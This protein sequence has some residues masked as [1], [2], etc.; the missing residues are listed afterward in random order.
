MIKVS[1]IRNN[2]HAHVNAVT[3][4]TSL[5]WSDKRKKKYNHGKLANS[6]P[7]WIIMSSVIRAFLTGRV[8]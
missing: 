6:R 1:S 7:L 3:V 8:R 4:W 2:S 5:T